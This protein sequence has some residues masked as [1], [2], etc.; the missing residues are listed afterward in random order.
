MGLN[1]ESDSQDEVC[2]FSSNCSMRLND[3]FRV[4]FVWTAEGPTEVEIVDYY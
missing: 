4:C 1:I 2:G 3:Q